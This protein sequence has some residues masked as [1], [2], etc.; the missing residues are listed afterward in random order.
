MPAPVYYKFYIMKKIRNIWAVMAV[1]ALA[2]S[3]GEDKIQV[4]EPEA[5]VIETASLRSVSGETA[6]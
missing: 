4:V 1:S 5:P 3:C 2:F 6:L